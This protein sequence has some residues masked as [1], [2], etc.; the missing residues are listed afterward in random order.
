MEV[1]VAKISRSVS[2]SLPP[3]LVGILFVRV[4]LPLRMISASTVILFRWIFIRVLLLLLLLMLLMLL[5]LLIVL[6]VRET[7][8]FPFCTFLSI[9]KC[10]I[11][12]SYFLHLVF[13]LTTSFVRMVL[14]SHLVVG[15]FDF[16]VRCTASQL[17]DFPV[18]RLS[19]NDRKHPSWLHLNQLIII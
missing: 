2:M 11:G 17:E 10:F 8:F 5:M 7:S 6:I 12:L 9:T 4:I 13:R 15:N 14:L 18:V 1:D 19:T 16:F 3:A